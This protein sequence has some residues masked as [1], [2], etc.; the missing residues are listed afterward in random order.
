MRVNIYPLKSGMRTAIVYSP[1]CLEHNP[2]IR[3]P[4]RPER[5][6]AILEGL[7]K[8]GLLTSGACSIVEPE[9]ASSEDLQLVHQLDYISLVELYCE[10]G[11]GIL[12]LG[13]TV[14]SKRSLEA[15]LYAV[16]GALKAVNLVMDGAFKNAFALIRP[17]G[18]HAGTDYAS[19]FCLFNNVAMT[20]T[21]LLK[22][23][24]LKRIA[25]LDIDAH[26][27]NGT[28][29]IFYETDEVLY[30]SMH[31]DP[32]VSFPGTGFANEVGRGRGK[33]Y[34]VN[35]P[36][37]LR[38]DD[39]I[40]L[41]AFNDVVVPIVEQFGPQFILTSIGFDCHHTD[42]VARLSLSAYAYVEVLNAILNLASR[43]CEDKLAAVLEG[44]Y[45]LSAIGMLT[46]AVISTLAE[47]PYPIEDKVVRAS[48]EVRKEAERMLA[49]VKRVHS[50]YWD[51]N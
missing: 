6:K 46:T 16:G 45:S 15:A 26:H 43:F 11:G 42:P 12:D 51:I 20:A 47:V 13:D 39:Q 37:P 41:T 23:R 32:T 24:G 44:G 7:N 49:E 25:I 21:H 5:L 19:G 4:E 34:T 38:A 2:G 33:G 48:E 10:R 27:G 35:I 40:Y 9:P 36:L 17:P 8:S 14:V 18:H 28:Q 31:M 22:R 50:A 1:K 3:H 29:E 30:V